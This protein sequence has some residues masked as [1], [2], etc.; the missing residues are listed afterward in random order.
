MI[1]AVPSKDTPPMLRAVANAVAV[2]ASATDMLL[3]P[4]KL[5]PPI[6][7]AVSNAVAVLALPVTSP[8]SGP[9]KASDVTVPSKKAFLN[10]AEDVP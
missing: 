4:S 8:V 9:A 1:L 5:V 2:S 6:V 10:S 7:L 3:V